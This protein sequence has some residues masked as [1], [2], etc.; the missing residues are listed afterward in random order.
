MGLFHKELYSNANEP[1][2]CK[3][4]EWLSDANEHRNEGHEDAEQERKERYANNNPIWI[5]FENKKTLFV[6]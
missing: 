3:H 4:A 2:A 6:A 5:T 1:G